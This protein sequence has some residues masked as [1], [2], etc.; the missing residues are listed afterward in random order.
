MAP[1]KSTTIRDG[2]SKAFKSIMKQARFQSTITR[3]PIQV[4]A[5]L[6][7]SDPD[8]MDGCL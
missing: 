3:Q 2:R 7:R 8:A 5:L 1:R 4:S 6:P